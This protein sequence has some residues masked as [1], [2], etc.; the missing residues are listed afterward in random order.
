MGHLNRLDESESLPSFTRA[1]D[2]RVR[3]FRALDAFAVEAYQAARIVAQQEG[4]GLAD[5]IRRA[6]TRSGGALLGACAAAAGS[7]AEKRGL[8]SARE[9]LLEGRYPLYL[10][11]RLG[12]FDVRRYRMLAARHD[13]ALRSI[14][15]LLA[16]ASGS[17]EARGP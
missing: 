13:T 14:E 6:L 16:T 2:G 17:L 3:A 7:A 10:A 11:R 15:A 9:G 5:E 8:E 4:M 1:T 12:L